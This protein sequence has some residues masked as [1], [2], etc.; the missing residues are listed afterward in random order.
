MN[1]TKHI[2]EQLLAGMPLPPDGV[3]GA[4]HRSVWGDPH[5]GQPL[6]AVVLWAYGPV[7]AFLT[8][9]GLETLLYATLPE[10]AQVLVDCGE[11]LTGAA[12]AEAKAARS[13]PDPS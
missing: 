13:T 6:G 4:V 12:R 5:T 1:K 11:N 3:D 7:S 8:A 9:E 2:L 10:A